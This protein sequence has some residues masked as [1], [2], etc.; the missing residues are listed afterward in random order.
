MISLLQ[1]KQKIKKDL[2][3][4]DSLMQE[5]IYSDDPVLKPKIEYL[6]SSNGKRL[7]PIL[8]YLVSRIYGEPTQRTHLSAVIIETLHS[9]SLI[10][11]DV[12]DNAKM[13]RGKDSLNNR[14][15]NKTA[16]LLG[17]F[18]FAKCMEIIQKNSLYDIFETISP[19]LIDLSFGELQQLDFNKKDN[20]SKE[21]YFEVIN[22]KTAS[23]ISVSCICGANSAGAQPEQ[24]KYLNNF[25]IILGQIFQI[26]DDIL[27]YN[28]ETA[29]FGKKRFNDIS[30]RKMTL[31]LILA[32]DNAYKNKKKEILS[33]WD[34]QSLSEEEKH[35]IK[36]FVEEEKGIVK[37][38]EIIEQLKGKAFNELTNVKSSEYTDIL[39]KLPDLISTR[40]K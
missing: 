4:F 15:D 16:V 33:L 30:E 14:F 29:V 11:D 24:L 5:Y 40:K 13:R 37:S 27:D 38:N 23:L 2:S 6:F 26:S 35:Y 34:K 39:Q 3:T 7:R 9:A 10:H 21:D 1:I 28:G 19:V 8:V 32:L 12:V 17:D 31:P 20:Y 25:G 18:L 22:K 36:N